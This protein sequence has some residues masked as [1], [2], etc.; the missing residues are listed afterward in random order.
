MSALHVSPAPPLGV[1]TGLRGSGAP[2][3]PT[4]HDV[5]RFLCPEFGSVAAEARVHTTGAPWYRIVQAAEDDT[6]DSIVMATQG[7]DS[8][9]DGIVGSNTDRVLR[10]A[11]CSVLVA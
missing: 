5:R 9:R 7:N 8:V 10:H 3:A 4:E 6:S 2:P 1:L 11:P